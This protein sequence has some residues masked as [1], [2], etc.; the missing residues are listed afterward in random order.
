MCRDF[1]VYLD[2]MCVSA[3][4]VLRYTSGFSFDQLM[5]DEKTFDAVVRNLEI[6][7][8]AA[9]HIPPEIRERYPGV[10]WRRI[11]GL[12]D[13]VIHEYF[14]M[15]EDILWDIVQNQI[16]RLLEQVRQILAVEDTDESVEK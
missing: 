5:N 15:D 10:E 3:E 1:R 4:K 2:D 9:K 7:G 13:I 8:E 14:G 12:R 11:A 6:I 16:P